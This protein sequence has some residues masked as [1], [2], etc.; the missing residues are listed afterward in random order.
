VAAVLADLAVR[1]GVAGVA[2]TL[3]VVAVVAGLLASGRI[4]GLEA[5]CVVC[6]DLS[7][8][9]DRSKS[10]STPVREAVCTGGDW[11]FDGWA[12]ANTSRRRALNARR[13]VCGP[14]GVR[15]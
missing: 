6:A 4:A 14:V 11:P 1:S 15:R 8:P 7:D 5:A 3:V 2:R 12:A 9:A 10:R 13:R